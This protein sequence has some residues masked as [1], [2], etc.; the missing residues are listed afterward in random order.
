MRWCTLG[1]DFFVC[2]C[3][4]LKTYWMYTEFFGKKQT[5]KDVPKMCLR[6]NQWFPNITHYTSKGNR[7]L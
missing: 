6:I 4:K 1:A 5:E 2:D 7:T 3:I